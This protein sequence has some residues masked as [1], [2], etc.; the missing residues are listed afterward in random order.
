MRLQGKQASKE[1][2]APTAGEVQDQGHVWGASY[3]YQL[4]I[5][6]TRCVLPLIVQAGIEQSFPACSGTHI[7]KLIK[8]RQQ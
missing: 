1:A 7:L 3:P 6:F 4:R 8:G 2:A 5:L